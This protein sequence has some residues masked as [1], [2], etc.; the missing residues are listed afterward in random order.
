MAFSNQHGRA[1][2]AGAGERALLHMQAQH[3]LAWPSHIV[4]LLDDDRMLAVGR[5]SN[6]MHTPAKAAAA[7]PVAGSSATPSE[8]ANMRAVT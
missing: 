7:D 1:A 4:A 2:D 5:P 6:A 3:D 8:G